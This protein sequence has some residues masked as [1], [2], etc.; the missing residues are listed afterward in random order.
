MAVAVGQVPVLGILAWADITPEVLRQTLGLVGQ[1]MRVL[2]A[3][4]AREVLAAVAPGPALRS[5]AGLT[6]REE[7]VLRELAAKDT[8]GDIA[9]SLE[10]AERTLHDIVRALKRKL[11]V[12]KPFMLGA[13]AHALGLVEVEDSGEWARKEAATSS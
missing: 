7:A 11:K 1:G 12:R 2:S 6:E 9:A 10:I 13:W 5:K 4:A 8:Q 3:P